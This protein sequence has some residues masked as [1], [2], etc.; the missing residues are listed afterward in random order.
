MP[1]RSPSPLLL[2]VLALCATVIAVLQTVV[3]PAL[4]QIGDALGSTPSATGWVLTANLLAAAVLTPVLGRLGDVHSRRP[5]LLGVLAAVAAGSLL[6]AV[7][8]S[9]PL[10]VLARVVQG[11]SYSLFPLSIGVLRDELPAARLTGAM[12]VVSASLGA[13]GGF[14]LV[15]TGLLLRGG[16]DYHR[17]FWVALAVTLVALVL[18]SRVVPRREPAATGTVD[19]TGAVVLGAGLVL[20]LL[21]LSQAHTW[22]WG[23][24]ATLG[25]LAACAVVL[26]GWY[27]LR[28]ARRR[29][30]RRAGDAALAPAPGH[31][32]RRRP[33]RRRDVRVVPRGELVRPDPDPG[34]LRLLLHRARRQR[35]LPAARRRAR[36]ARRAARRA[37]RRPDRSPP[38]AGAAA[39]L[40]AAGFALMAVLHSASWELI[41]GSVLVN[42]AVSLAF[43]SLPAIIVAEVSPAQTGVANSL[44]SIARSVGSSL[45]SAVVVTLL[46][47]EVLPSGLPQLRRR[48]YRRSRSAGAPS[49]PPPRWCWSGC[50]GSRRRAGPSWRRRPRPRSPP[51]GASSAR[52][53]EDP[54]AGS[55]TPGTPA[56]PRAASVRRAPRSGHDPS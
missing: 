53:P 26:T 1:S 10:L 41:T 6:A 16:G 4:A 56:R 54:G 40:G 19:W 36:R 44:N 22:G 31:Q 39:L 50:P 14:G 30:A 42:A 12:A 29:P 38:G 24:P 55:R 13:G 28:D 11:A 46:A 37:A 52:G 20:L 18:A 33:D 34:R 8:T 7:T 3:V 9:L 25:C 15:I 2:P 5:V 49:S 47:S 17:V 23:S 32:R 35:H 51:S 43:A 27:A 21:P 48:T 45:A